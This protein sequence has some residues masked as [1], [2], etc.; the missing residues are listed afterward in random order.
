MSNVYGIQVSSLAKRVQ[1]NIAQSKDILR[2][3]VQIVDVFTRERA[4]ST[5]TC[6]RVC[7]RPIGEISAFLRNNDTRTDKDKEKRKKKRN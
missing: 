6:K 5:Y 4:V 1:L 7:I 2:I 3:N